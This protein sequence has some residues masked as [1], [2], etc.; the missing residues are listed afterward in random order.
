MFIG[1]NLH[2]TILA[3]V[4][5][6]K[7]WRYV[8]SKYKEFYPKHVKKGGGTSVVSTRHEATTNEI[9]SYGPIP[10][11]MYEDSKMNCST[12]VILQNK[13]CKLVING[14]YTAQNCSSKYS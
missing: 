9:S 2:W 12:N 3:I 6:V 7:V 11:P 1:F 4:F 13:N 5:T 10:L 8:L 14:I